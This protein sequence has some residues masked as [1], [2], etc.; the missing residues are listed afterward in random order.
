M[1]SSDPYWSPGPNVVQGTNFRHK[2][3]VLTKQCER[4]EH[5]LQVLNWDD[6]LEAQAEENI[7]VSQLGARPPCAKFPKFWPQSVHGEFWGWPQTIMT[8]AS[9]I[10]E[11][12]SQPAPLNLIVG[13]TFDKPVA[14][15]CFL[16]IQLTIFEKYSKRRSDPDLLWR[17]GEQQRIAGIAH[18]SAL[19]YTGAVNKDWV[20]QHRE[21]ANCKADLS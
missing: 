10:L 1:Q 20:D 15:C 18:S 7:W 17:R 8:L 11:G 9:L 5:A 21:S 6:I 12:A 16:E 19:Q 13:D 14:L 2:A 4:W 3:S